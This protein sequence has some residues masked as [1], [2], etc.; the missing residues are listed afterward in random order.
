MPYS[1][2]VLGNPL[3]D[4][5]AVV[6]ES[7]LAKYNIKANDA[8][9]AEK[10]HLGIFNDLI[11]NYNAISLAGGAAQNTARGAQYVLP[12]NSVVYTGAVGDDKF[13]Q[14]LRDANEKEGVRSVYQVEKDVP[15]G[16]CAVSI[17][18][19]NR[20][21]VTDLAAANH[22][23]VDHLRKPEVW[24]LVEQAGFYYVGGYHLTV[25]VPAILELGQHASETNKLF[26]INLSAPFLAQF[27]KS[28]LDSVL[29]YV[30]VLIGN[31]SEA[32]AFAESHGIESTDVAEI[33]SRIALLPKQNG[34]RPRQVVI[35]QGSLAT[36]IVTAN[37]SGTATSVKE[38]AIRQI[39]DEDLV[40]TNGAGDSFAGGFIGALVSGKTV[41]E[42][43]EYGH[44]LASYTVRLSGPAY[45]YPKKEFPQ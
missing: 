4:I 40:D 36:I 30:D 8:I 3:L 11:D 43:V 19:T 42:A 7:F 20:S 29:P 38:Y 27:F 9:L 41:D 45:P 31:E 34:K 18:G 1:L 28:Q 35:T 10:E 32:A 5:Q 17:V 12:P 44:W 15:T 22:F 21:L 13:A 23:K 37:E 25:S 16:K 33:A 26:S 6:P 24:Q 2:F 14:L 39:A